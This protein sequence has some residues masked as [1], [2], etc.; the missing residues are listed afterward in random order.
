[1]KKIA[2]WMVLGLGA[3]V[4][5]QGALAAQ[6]RYDWV[7]Q[8][9]Y[10]YNHPFAAQLPAELQTK[11]QK[12]SAS[13]FAFYRGTAHLFFADMVTRPASMYTSYATSQTWLNG[14]M[15]LGNIGGF[16]DANGNFVYDTT[17][18]DEG[19]WGPYGWDL[20]RMAVSI[21]L[22]ASENGL[23]STERQQLVRDFLD[24]YLNKMGDFRGTDEE[25]S[26]RLTAGNTSGEVKNVI[27]KSAS[28]TRSD[29]LS[30]YTTLVSSR[31]VFLTS[32]DMQAVSG[33]RYSE[34]QSAVASYVST[35]P[36]AKRYANSYYTVKDVRQKL[37]SG[38]GSLGRYRYYV[39]V[40][41]PSTSQSDD[42]ILQLKQESTSVVA[43]A[44]PGNFP[45]WAYD[46][47]E[48]ARATKSMKANLSNTDRLA[49]WSTLG[50]APYF[51]REKSPYEADFDYTRLTSYG[52][53]STAVQY[54]GKVV[55]KNHALSDKD[56]DAT[57]KPYSIDKEIDDVLTGNKSEFK[58]ELVQ[59]AVDY[60]AQVKLDFQSFMSA[61]ASGVPLY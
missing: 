38:V 1:M 55:A 5:A 23:G 48:G 13:P 2:A 51:V 59:F 39:L 35:I 49:G 31:R 24:A 10:G 20:R 22:A 60:A 41:G 33:A 25:L 12:M 15:H 11:V 26:Y 7:V 8:Q 36:S 54:M 43:A 47:H 16:R 42:V 44:A 37:G 45:A 32:T 50:G 4:G 52:A 58:D 34:I 27:Q 53:F 14:D 30:K 29:L 9:I 3:L 56:Y 6:P 19:Y 18:F 28:Q 21:V 40:E 61:Y 46:S 57:L 17:D